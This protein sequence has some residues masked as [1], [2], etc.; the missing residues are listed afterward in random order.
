LAWDGLR[1]TEDNFDDAA[2]MGRTW[3]RKLK[4]VEEAKIK[5]KADERAEKESVR[6]KEKDKDKAILNTPG[7]FAKGFKCGGS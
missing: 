6:E 4:E 3:E 7:A 2:R 1:L 5:G